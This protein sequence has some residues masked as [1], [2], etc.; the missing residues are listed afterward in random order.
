MGKIF[1]NIGAGAG[2]ALSTYLFVNGGKA[3]EA[4]PAQVTTEEQQATI[5]Y[6]VPRLLPDDLSSIDVLHMP[7]DEDPAH[8]GPVEKVASTIGLLIVGTAVGGAAGGLI[9]KQFK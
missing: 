2:L 3:P 8:N 5:S 6:G 9:D 7:W 4:T 1:R